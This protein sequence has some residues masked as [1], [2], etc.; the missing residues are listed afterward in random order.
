M[1]ITNGLAELHQEHD[2]NLKSEIEV[3]C[4]NLPSDINELKPGNRLKDKDHLKKLNEQL[5]APRKDVKQPE[6]LPAITTTST[7]LATSTTCTATVP[8]QLSRHQCLFSSKPGTSY[9]SKSYNPFSS[10]SSTVEAVC[11]ASN[12]TSFPGAR[13]S[14]GG[15]VK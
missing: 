2:L 5:S 10:S 7:T 4:K 13:P 8:P 15:L 1:A 6:E 12:C 11:A 14:C 9:N 3:L